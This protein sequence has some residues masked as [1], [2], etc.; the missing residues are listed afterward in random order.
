M[1]RDDWMFFVASMS[2]G[3][4]GVRAIIVR[5]MGNPPVPCIKSQQLFVCGSVW[6]WLFALSLCA[7]YL[8]D[9]C[10]WQFWK[11]CSVAKIQKVLKWQF[12][13]CSNLRLPLR[14]KHCK[15]QIGTVLWHSFS[16]LLYFI[17]SNLI[18]PVSVNVIIWQVQPIRYLVGYYTVFK[19][20][21]VPKTK[22]TDGY[23]K[24][25]NSLFPQNV[26]AVYPPHQWLGSFISFSE[27]KHCWNNIPLKRN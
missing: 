19:F 26:T 18:N 6:L 13:N 22:I 24:R 25:R 2:N 5:P 8:S 15:T 11:E 21:S 7:P 1:L 12:W 23:L 17:S 20:S 27:R 16:N 4:W 3:E 9:L 10:L 14:K